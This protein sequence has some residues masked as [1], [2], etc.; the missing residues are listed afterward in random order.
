MTEGLEGVD[1]RLIAYA[2]D[3]GD[4]REVPAGVSASARFGVGRVTG[5]GGCNRFA[6]GWRAM[7]DGLAIGPLAGTMMACDEAAMAVEAAFHARLAEV[8]RAMVGGESLDLLGADARVLLRFHASG[9]TLAGVRWIATGV[10]DGRGGVAS[11]LGGSEISAEFSGEDGRVAGS[12][13]CN[14]FS[15][16]WTADGEGLTISPLAS[17]RR[18]CPGP[19]GVMDQEAAFL[20]AMGRVATYG[21]DGDQLDLR[22]ADGALQVSFRAG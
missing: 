20:A 13:G 17:T 12:A 18:L 22:A 19:E 16:T 4:L 5:S 21:I 15:G 3:D 9:V 8:A 11:V 7:P 1:W 14:R 6:G 2:G 10:N